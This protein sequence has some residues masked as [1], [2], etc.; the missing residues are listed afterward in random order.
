MSPKQLK[1]I[2]T[3]YC[4]CCGEGHL[5]EVSNPYKLSTLTVMHK[6]CPKCGADFMKEPGFYFGASYVSYALTVALWVAVV[7]ALLTFDAIGLIEYGFLTHPMTF[8][9]TGITLLLLLVPIIF[10]VSRSI[11]LAVFTEPRA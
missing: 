10:R 1:T 6:S 5:F 2:L 9:G 8:L 3:C 11:W 4:P 7:V